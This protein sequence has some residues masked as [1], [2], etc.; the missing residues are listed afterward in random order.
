MSKRL[1]GL[2]RINIQS[3]IY[4]ITLMCCTEH[5]CKPYIFQVISCSMVVTCYRH[6]RAVLKSQVT[7]ELQHGVFLLQAGCCLVFAMGLGKGVLDA[8]L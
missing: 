8:A 3:N 4:F 1:E 2:G 7:W 5:V 6:T